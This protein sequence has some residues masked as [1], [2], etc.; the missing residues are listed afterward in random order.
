MASHSS[1]M[2]LSTVLT[3]RV[4]DIDDP[5]VESA[6]SAGSGGSGG[7]NEPSAEQVAMLADMGFTTAQAKK[8]LR[9]TVSPINLLVGMNPTQCV[10]RVGRRPRT[11]CG[12]ALQPP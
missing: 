8:A 6:P 12:V 11:S 1:F 9:E 7:G 2:R 3:V 5:I 10:V 4:I